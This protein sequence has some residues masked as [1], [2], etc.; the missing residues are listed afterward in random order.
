MIGIY[1]FTN[2]LNNKKYIGQSKS[3]ESRYKRHLAA[4]KSGAHSA[5]YAAIRK[6]G[7]ENFSFSVVQ[8]CSLEELNDL[9][10]YYIR[11]YNTRVPNGYNIMPGGQSTKTESTPY[12]L[13]SDDVFVIYDLLADSEKSFTEIAE[14]CNLTSTM[15]GYIN[16]GLE[17]AQNGVQYPIRQPEQAKA[18]QYKTVSHKLQGENSYR[19][20]ISEQTALDIIYDLSFNLDLSSVAIAQKYHVTT[21]VVKDINRGKS[22]KHLFRK[23]PCRPDFGNH[24]ITLDD[25]LFIIQKLKEPILIQD[26][27]KMNPLYSYHIV[28]RI[29]I[30]EAWKQDNEHYPI[31]TF[32]MKKGKLTVQQVFQIY[33][34]ALLGTPVK[35]IAEKFNISSQSVY[36]ILNFKT[37]SYLQQFYH[38]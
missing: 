27:C 21:D 6:Y 25:A 15:M 8:E 1:Q 22:W 17:Y 4:A 5:L 36:D 14:M 26:I 30:G 35:E 13:T 38:M 2:N 28:H 20:T 16:Q 23:V 3:I 34:E 9:E 33:D 29:N 19:A 10:K 32:V 37:Y 24:T 18:I 31:R 12:R 7:I 11:T